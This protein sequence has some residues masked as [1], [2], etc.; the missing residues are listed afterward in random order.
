MKAA[1][2]TN[3][4]LEFAARQL[5]NSGGMSLLTPDGYGN[6]A[7]PLIDRNSFVYT[8]NVESVF[9]ILDTQELLRGRNGLDECR[10]EID[11]VMNIFRNFMISEKNRKVF[12]SSSHM[13]NDLI[14]SLKSAG[15]GLLLESLWNT[16]LHELNRGFENLFVFPLNEIIQKMGT[17]EFYSDKMWYLGGMKYSMKAQNKIV[18]EMNRIKKALQKKRKKCLVLDLD[19]TLWGGVIGE[20]GA[21]GIELSEF[22]EGAR[23]KDFQKRIMEIKNLG[24][25]LAIC[26]KN[27]Y[28]DAIEVINSHPHMVL[29]EEDFVSLKINWEQKAKNISEI[30]SELNIGTDSLVFIDDNPVERESVRMLMPEVAVPEFPKDT[31]ELSKFI[32]GVYEEY[33]YTVDFTDEDR[34]KTEMYRQNNM[35]EREKSAAGDLESFLKGLQTEIAIGLLKPGDV[36]RAAELTQKTNQFNLTTRRYSEER[37]RNFMD[38]D[39]YRVYMASAKD[40]YGDNGKI[41]LVIAKLEGDSAFVDTFVM[42]CRVMGRY[43]EEQIIG[44]VENDLKESGIRIIKSEFI[45]TGK[46]KPVCLLYENLG[47]SVEEESDSGK[48]YTISIANIPERKKYGKLVI[49]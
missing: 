21:D 3:I 30:A 29:K 44:F 4:N 47:Y 24:V 34:N 43:I 40:K 31:A 20:D 9:I 7:Q 45:P 8:E 36:K 15:I 17:D 1:L 49:I 19:N 13:K 2:L 46:N 28:D 5:K 35:R 22:K 33:F 27:N 18:A 41:G 38:S 39:E 42:S 48:K 32:R 14:C 26:S 6:W 16:G 37:I 10:T 23:Y 11:G 25:L 12:I